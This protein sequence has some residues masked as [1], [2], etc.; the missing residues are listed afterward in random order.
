MTTPKP[1]SVTQSATNPDTHGDP[2]PFVVVGTFP[3]EA[4]DLTAIEGYDAGKAS[5]TLKSVLGVIKWVT[6]A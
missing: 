5:Q 4:V 6:D 1:I 3:P 2:Q